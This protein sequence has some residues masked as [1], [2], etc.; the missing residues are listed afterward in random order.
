MITDQ[1][2]Q[3]ILNYVKESKEIA[4]R[5]CQR[6][7]CGEVC[8]GEPLPDILRRILEALDG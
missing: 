8:A 1:D 5:I 2:I 6:L 3:D 4:N 7:D